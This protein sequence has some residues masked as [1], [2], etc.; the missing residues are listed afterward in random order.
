MFFE[1][2]ITVD[3]DSIITINFSLELPSMEELLVFMDFKVQSDTNKGH[4]E[5]FAFKLF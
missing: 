3:C 4:F 1:C 5:A 2:K